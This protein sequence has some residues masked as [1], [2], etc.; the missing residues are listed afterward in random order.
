MR[1]TRSIAEEAYYRSFEADRRWGRWYLFKVV[2]ANPLSA[3]AWAY[4]VAIHTPRFFTRRFGRLMR[5]VLGW[6]ET[7]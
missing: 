6:R 4:F 2:L 5:Q 3:Y 7:P 1:H